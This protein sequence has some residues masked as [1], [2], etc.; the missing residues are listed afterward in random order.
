MRACR[1]RAPPR[2]GFT[3]RCFVGPSSTTRLF[4]STHFAASTL[5][6]SSKPGAVASLPFV[7]FGLP[8]PFLAILAVW[9]IGSDRLG[10]P[11]ELRGYAAKR[12]HVDAA[13]AGAQ[14]ASGSPR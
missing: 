11:F 8:L 9:V 10:R 1:P 14:S 12:R 3:G 4:S 5:R 13:S 2:A 7:S 6:L